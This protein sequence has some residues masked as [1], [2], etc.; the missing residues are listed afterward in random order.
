LGAEEEVV[1]TGL[2]GYPAGCGGEAF[3]EGAQDPEA[4]LLGAFVAGRAQEQEQDVRRS[5][6]FGVAGGVAADELGHLGKSEVPA[7]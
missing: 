4:H 7:R 2:S 3:T 5:R 1:G 6:A